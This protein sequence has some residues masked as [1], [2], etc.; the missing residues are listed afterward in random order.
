MKS[1]P[2]QVLYSPLNSTNTTGVSSITGQCFGW[3][4]R[5]G[6]LSPVWGNDLHTRRSVIS[7]MGL[8]WLASFSIGLYSHL[9]WPGPCLSSSDGCRSPTTQYV[10]ITMGE[11]RPSL[12]QRIVGYVSKI[13]INLAMI[14][15]ITLNHQH[16]L[17]NSIKQCWTAW[18]FNSVFIY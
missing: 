9:F 17:W 2:N 4:L 10:G 15:S 13:M 1:W 12:C 16:L 5:V 8:I 14:F 6:P 11:R 18:T 3:W 7:C